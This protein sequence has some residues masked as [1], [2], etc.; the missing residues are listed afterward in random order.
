MDD[1]FPKFIVEDGKLVIEKIT[2]HKQLV[3]NKDNVRG[4]G[5]F[6]FIPETKTILLYGSSSD[7]GKAKLEDVSKAVV[8]GWC[9]SL[10]CDG[11]YNDF[12]FR[13]STCEKL[14]D[15]LSDNTL[16]TKEENG[17]D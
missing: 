15:A 16:I 1:V 17:K 9:D 11:T 3:V 2:F 4:G 12:R 7:F 5:W 13:F 8:N 10:Y 6:H 14:E